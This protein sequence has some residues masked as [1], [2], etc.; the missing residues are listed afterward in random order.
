LKKAYLTID[1]A[2][3]RDFIA[4]TEFLD[5]HGIPALF[6][7]EGQFIQQNERSLFTA[8]ELGFLIGNHSFSHPHFSDLSVEECKREIRQTDALIEHIYRKIGVA[9]TAKYFRFPYF[10][11]GGDASAVAYETKWSKPS[12]EWFR[13]E[14]DDRR[15]ELQ[16]YLR[17]LGYRQPQFQ[18]INP[19]YFADP[20]LLSGVDVHCTYDQ[21]EYWLHEVNAPWGLSKEEA[22]LGRIEEDFPYEG[23]SL[24]CEDTV[25]IVLVHDHEKTTDLFYQ[26]IGRFIEKGIDFLPIPRPTM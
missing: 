22:I 18:G 15:Q 26:I 2:P 20:N 23:R 17:G 9:W 19:Q 16:D 25:D 13:Y 4:K 12:A 10:D 14:R 5:R 3:S 11:S 24:N 8:I 21:A 1:D 7:C 6:F